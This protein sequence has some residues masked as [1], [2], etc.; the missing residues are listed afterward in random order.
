[1]STFLVKSAWKAYKENRF[2]EALTLF[3]E[4][5]EIL[6]ID[7]FK[8]NII[9]LQKKLGIHIDNHQLKKITIPYNHETSK[10]QDASILINRSV[11]STHELP[12]MVSQCRNIIQEKP[13]Y[14]EEWLKKL[15]IASIMDE[16]TWQSY[17]PEADMLQLTPENWHNELET[18]NPDMLFVESAWRGKDELWTN[19]VHKNP[20]ALKGILQWCHTHNVPTVFWNKEDP[21]HFETFINTAFL[22]DFIFTYDF[23]CVSRYKALLNH[24]H[25]YYLPMGVQTRM[26]NPIE[27]YDRKDA[28]CFAGSY[29]KR[30]P[31]RTQNLEEYILNLPLIKPVEIFDRQYGK[32]DP[33]YMFP[34]N[35]LPF[36]K[37]GLP[38]NQIDK[39]YKG[40]TYAINLNSLKQAQ[41]I[42]RRVYE[43]MACNTLVVSNFSRGVHSQMGE[44]TILSDSAKEVIR[45]IKEIESSPL[46]AD[47]LRLAALRKVMLESTYQDRLAYI[48]A[49]VCDVKTPSLLP[50]V[51]VV[52]YPDTQDQAESVYTSFSC[53]NYAEKYLFLIS[54]V[55]FKISREDLRVHLLSVDEA[56]AALSALPEQAWLAYFAPEDFYGANYLTDIMLAT[57]Y[58]KSQVIG[59]FCFYSFTGSKI[60]LCRDDNAHP[61]TER[62]QRIPARRAVANVALLKLKNWM[63]MNKN[64]DFPVTMSF[65]VDSLNYLENGAKSTDKDKAFLCDKANLDTGIS[66]AQMQAYAEQ[67]CPID[68]IEMNIPCLE[69]SPLSKEF[70]PKAPIENIETIVTPEGYFQIS[71][72]LSQDEHTYL[73]G[74]SIFSLKEIATPANTV[75]I[76]L[77]TSGG[78][79]VQIAG[80]FLDQN[81]QK[82]QYIM[83]KSNTNATLPI[84]AKAAFIRFALRIQGNGTTDVKKLFFDHVA[85]EPEC[86]VGIQETLII[87]NQYPS[88]DALYRNAFVHSRACAYKRAGH[89]VSVY[90]FKTNRQLKFDEFEGVAVFRGGASALRKILSTGK[91]RRILVHFLNK[92]MWDVLKEIPK[93]VR[94]IVWVHG[95][96]IQPWTR[97]IYNYTSQ[98]ELEKAKLQSDVRVSFWKNIFKS[99]PENIHFVF[100]SQHFASEIMEDYNIKLDTDR[101]SIIH[102]PIDTELFDYC[103]KNAEHR[104]KLLSIR[105][106]ASRKYANDLTVK[107]ILKLSERHDFNKFSI[108]IIGNGTLFDEVVQP[109]RCMPNVTI[110][111]AFLTHTEIATIQKEY[112]IFLTPT[113]WDSQGVSRDES[114]SSGLVPVTNAVAAI[115]EFV[116]ESCAILAPANDAIAMAAGISS[117][118]DDP[119]LFLAMSKAA[120]QRVREQTAADIIIKQ[121]LN[122]II[123]G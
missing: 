113:R 86:I 59:K 1:M 87:T 34:D 51:Y 83:F 73:Y 74:G 8:A 84:C 55:K 57:R 49:K 40:Y 102:N 122:L 13:E 97:R 61:Y 76:N 94:I 50:P 98:Q 106:Y 44:L 15:R 68:Q 38:Y 52:A 14:F 109:L 33:N 99:L 5:A 89:N 118:V 16:F 7:N 77:Q 6:G 19:I 70:T 72:K 114:M 104:Y 32:D 10:S 42:A 60:I 121:E 30:Y 66:V 18:F 31:E 110:E 88:Y 69:K 29:Y 100:V 41:S 112:G 53:Q 22:F 93:N 75:K 36:I 105:S 95:A 4:A 71:S 67:T 91:V 46:S 108:K 9:L 107:C 103:K 78:L 48:V 56:P 116:D 26:F 20:P 117:L 47:K 101:Y 37:G 120:A 123:K 63:P 81:K 12:S 82:L 11:Q 43:L 23:H 2:K 39:A 58:Q 64:M 28:F 85:L 35:Y 90:Q 119:A 96:D 79:N 24:N 17:S 45:R 62:K 21:I 65:A 27:K 25:V 115:P 3:S 54:D 92:D 111:K 80:F